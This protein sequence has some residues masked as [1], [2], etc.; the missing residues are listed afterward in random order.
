VTAAPHGE[1]DATPSGRGARARA[2]LD[3]IAGLL[4]AASIA[5][6]AVGVAYRPFRLLPVALLLALIAAGIGGRNAALARWA[7][8]LTVPFWLA[9]MIVAVVTKNPVF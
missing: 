1:P 9:G 8:F 2:A 5:L 6:G 3:P 4:A 7:C